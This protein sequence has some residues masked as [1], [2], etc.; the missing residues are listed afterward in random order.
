MAPKTN[1]GRLWDAIAARNTA[2]VQS[3][4]ADDPSLLDTRPPFGGGSWLHLAAAL[5][6]LETVTHLVKSGLSVNDEGRREGDRPLCCAAHNDNVEVAKFL[7]KQGSLLDTSKSV[8]NPLFAAIVGRSPKV[9]SLLLGSGIDAS[10]RYNSDTMTNMDATAFALWR[11]ENEI[12]SIIARHLARG[13]ETQVRER[14]NEATRIVS[15]NEPLQTIR[16]V[17]EVSDLDEG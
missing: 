4:L 11:G 12:A 3:V 5:G 14:L 17:P 9:V 13:D 10:V 7:I 15:G 1:A 8:R 16:I 6:N 2:E